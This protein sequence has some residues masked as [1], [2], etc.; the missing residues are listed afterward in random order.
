MFVTV[1]RE[2]AYR[3]FR[4]LT[5]CSGHP[6]HGFRHSRR[7]MLRSQES[8]EIV[9]DQHRL[10]GDTQIR[11]VL[12]TINE[13]YILPVSSLPVRS[14]PLVMI[15]KIVGLAENLTPTALIGYG[16]IGKTSIALTDPHRQRVNNDLVTTVGSTFIPCDQIATSCAHFLSQLSK[17]IGARPGICACSCLLFATVVQKNGRTFTSP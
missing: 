7:D 8:Q 2:N 15:E 3:R 1:L 13:F 16:G 11:S 12:S 14:P 6:R 10:V 4:G 9:R 5:R 17:V